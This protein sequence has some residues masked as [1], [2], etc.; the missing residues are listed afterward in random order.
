[1]TN[2]D[3][4]IVY[5]GIINSEFRIFLGDKK[6]KLIFINNNESLVFENLK[7]IIDYIFIKLK[8]N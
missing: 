8:N 4:I 5:N 7:K 1:M 6:Y 2:L 3:N